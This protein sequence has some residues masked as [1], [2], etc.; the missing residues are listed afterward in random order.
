M[1]LDDV[2]AKSFDSWVRACAHHTPAKTSDSILLQVAWIGPQMP[3]LQRKN[4]KR[5]LHNIQLHIC[6]E[7]AFS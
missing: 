4:A 6:L 2:F 7:P 5:K 3:Q 1:M